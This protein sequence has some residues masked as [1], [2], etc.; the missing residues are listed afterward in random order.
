M[1]ALEQAL[2]NAFHANE[3]NG[4]DIN[5]VEFTPTPFDYVDVLVATGEASE[6]DFVD[7][8]DYEPD[9]YDDSMD[10]DHASALASAG[11]GTDEDYGC[12]GGDE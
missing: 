5:A 3:F 9:Y 8:D 7:H 11:F 12:F 6:L 2:N 1:N 4:F 10:G